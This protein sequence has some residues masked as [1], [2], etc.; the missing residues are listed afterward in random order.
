MKS[1]L[2][3]LKNNHSAFREANKK[4]KAL[5]RHLDTLP[6]G[7][8]ASR[9]GRHLR[10]LKDIF[11]EK[12]AVAALN[13]DYKYR[14]FEDLYDK[15]KDKGYSRDEFLSL[16]D[17]MD[18][19]GAVT[20][21]MVDNKKHYALHQF[22]VGMYE[23]QAK[24][25]TAGFYIDSIKYIMEKF[26]YEYIS[27]AVPQSRVIP[28][29]KSITPEHNIA[30]YDEIRDIIEKT[31][32]RIAVQECICKKG[33]DLVGSPC[34]ATERREICL[35]F[36]NYSESYDRNGWGRVIPKEEALEILAQNEKDGLL[37]FLSGS[38]E[39]EFVC[40]CCGCCCGLMDLIRIAAR[41]ADFA[42]SNFRAAAD[43][44]LCNGCGRCVK[45]C[46]IKAIQFD[47]KKKRIT[48]V[49]KKRCIGCG[50]CIATCSP[51]ALT[52]KKK[53][54]QYIPPKDNEMLLEVIKENKKKGLKK[55]LF[56]TKALLGVKSKP[57][58][59]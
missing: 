30:T 12:E 54:Q 53:K 49:N 15:A 52:L 18:L 39:P 2:L 16:L 45:R 4:Y 57:E 38:Q 58:K 26:C 5:Q 34:K 43:P 28:I 41:P 46:H 24:S 44:A 13:L 14:S 17:S 27:T 47:G 51:G 42:A 20:V 7:Y 3:V 50:L 36:R 33:K 32:D 59:F 22:V 9:S 31:K 55:K 11:T 6:V 1:A 10:L 25:M 48:A 23:M 56:I 35:S 40:S 19:R 37:L 29:E 8:P 21:K